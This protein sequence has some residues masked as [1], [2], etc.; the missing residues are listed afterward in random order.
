MG[1][2]ISAVTQFLKGYKCSQV[3]LE[4]FCNEFDLNPDIARKITIPLAGGSGIG[5]LCGAVSGALLVIGLKYGFTNP[6]DPVKTRIV[7]EKNRE[8][9]EKF[10]AIH[11]EINCNKLINLDVFS[12]KGAQEFVEN[13]IK[14]IVCSKFVGDA[15]EILNEITK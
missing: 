3:V 7:I 10:K 11:S 15:V 5:G 6:G 14:E 12:E 4:A 13:N 2:K 8:F 1:E 9:V